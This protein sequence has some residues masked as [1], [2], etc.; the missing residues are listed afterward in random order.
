[1]AETDKN[2][3]SNPDDSATPPKSENASD[4]NGN[5]ISVG[6]KWLSGIFLIGLTVF[7]ALYIVGHWPDRLAPPRANVKP[8]YTYNWFHVRLVGIPD[9]GKV[10]YL[11][12]SIVVVEDYGLSK[13][14]QKRDTVEVPVS[15]ADRQK[16]SLKRINDSLRKNWKQEDLNTQKPS[17]RYPSENKLIHINTLLLILVA[18]AGFLGNMIYIATSFTT[19][20]GNGQFKRNWTLWYIVK[21]FTAAA[22]AVAIYFVF[23]GGFL[24]MSDDSTNINLYG[25]MTL[26]ILA[27]LFTD[28]TTLKLKEVFDVLLQPKEERAQ[29]LGD[30]GLEITNISP[31]VLEVGKAVPVTVTGK[32]LDKKNLKIKIDGKEVPSINGKDKITFSYT[33]PPELADKESVKLDI[34]DDKE[35]P[36]RRTTELKIKKP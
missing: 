31:E 30:S 16:D 13:V 36:V 25:L 1:M 4:V 9:T 24:N 27:G 18:V 26:S 19:F 32:N 2:V 6:G 8:L 21:P 29:P 11:N 23:R 12:D 14:P 20:I 7:S 5:E 15:I 35:T 3:A 28:R 34:V 10:E 17:T 33:V 22:L